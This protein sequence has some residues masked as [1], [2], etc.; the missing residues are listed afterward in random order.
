MTQ[1]IVR[2]PHVAV[3]LLMSKQCCQVTV[4]VAKRPA[5][6]RTYIVRLRKHPCLHID[7]VMRIR[8]SQGMTMPESLRAGDTVDLHVC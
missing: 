8:S 1:T 6:G 4:V 7:I 2:N 5:E 3:F